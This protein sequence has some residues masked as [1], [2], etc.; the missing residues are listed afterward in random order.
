MGKIHNNQSG[1]GAIEA[2]L[3]LIFVAIVAFIGVYVAHNHATSKTPAKSTANN[4]S[5]KTSSTPLKTHT[6]QEADA[7]VQTTYDSYL[8]AINNAGT[9]NTQP[10]GLVGLAAVK[11]NLTSDLYTLAAASQNGSSFSCAG[12]FAPSKYTASLASSNT[13][14][15]TVAL[16]IANS[17]D[18]S[19]TTNGMTATVDLTSLKITS[20]TCPSQ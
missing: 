13:K 19:T 16:A 2:L 5:V 3:G 14:S 8:A 7:F 12:Q 10:L 15:A 11:D 20:V 1:F 17:A 6:G 4:T 18:G 9:N